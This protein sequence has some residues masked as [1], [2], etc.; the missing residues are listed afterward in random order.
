[1]V[2]EVEG[3]VDLEDMEAMEEVVAVASEVGVVD[4]TDSGDYVI[5]V[6]VGGC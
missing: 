5:R 6:V 2:L 1:M 4:Q 3:V